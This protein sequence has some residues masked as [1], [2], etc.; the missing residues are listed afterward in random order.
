MHIVGFFFFF[1]FNDKLNQVVSEYEK[2]GQEKTKQPRF[3]V[4]YV[5]YIYTLI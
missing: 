3:G 1:F 4:E 2:K 5:E